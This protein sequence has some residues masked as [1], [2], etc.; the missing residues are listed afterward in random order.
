MEKRE[1][2]YEGKIK[3]LFLTDDPKAVIIEYKD[4]AT[5]FNGQ[6]KGIIPGKGIVNNKMSNVMFKILEKNGIE[7]HYIKELSD[8]ETCLKRSKIFPFEVIVR[9]SLAGS[10]AQR[11]GLEEG[12]R[13]NQRVIE[14]C[15]KN[16]KLGDPLINEYHIYALGLATKQQLE[17]IA[18]TAFMTNSIM[19]EYFA[20][21]GVELV[22]FKM[23]FGL[24]DG[25]IIVADEISPDTCRFWD[26]VTK[27]K[28]DKDRFRRDLGN[29]EGAYNEMLRRIEATL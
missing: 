24:Y 28:L 22:D 26:T 10:M 19:V 14:Y 6:K 16:G 18:D 25:R 12:M 13:L 29:T 20:S 8:R 21:I 23:E 15:F 2:L 17:K 9:N 7:T 4:N 11:L 3:T 5:A 27:E 1:L